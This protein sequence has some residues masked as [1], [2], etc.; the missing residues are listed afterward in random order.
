MGAIASQ[1]ISL[2]IF[3]P[4][5]YSDAD[6][7][8]H[9]SSASLAFVW[10]IPT[11][12]N[13]HL[14]T[15]GGGKQQSRLAGWVH[16]SAEAAPGPQGLPPAPPCAENPGAADENIYIMREIY[17]NSGAATTLHFFFKIILIRWRRGRIIKI[18]VML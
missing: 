11:F 14:S 18:Y 10:G 3:Y 5:V 12:G 2:M 4:T 6:Q 16:V 7:I 8:K 15:I 13:R 1:I 9:Q 17:I